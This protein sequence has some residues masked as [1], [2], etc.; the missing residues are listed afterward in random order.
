MTLRSVEVEEWNIFVYNFTSEMQM[1]QSTIRTRN[2]IMFFSYFTQKALVF[3]HEFTLLKWKC[4]YE[5]CNK[6]LS[7]ISIP[8][9]KL[10]KL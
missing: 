9:I 10:K 2:W 8:F 5:G 6:H 1:G 4:K 7:H 3:S